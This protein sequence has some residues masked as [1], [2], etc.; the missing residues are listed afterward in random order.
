MKCVAVDANVLARFL[1]GDPP[2]MAQQVLNLFAVVERGELTLMI[3]DIVLAEVVWVLTSFYKHPISEVARTLQ[4]LLIHEAIR[5]DDKALLVEALI[6]C[7]EHNVDFADALLAARMRRRGIAEV[8]SFD[9][10]FDR[11]PGI[12]RLHPDKAAHLGSETMA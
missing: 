10:H 7:A 2:D 8:I 12:L 11:L 5:A 3:D 9:H 1:T 4:Q 6:L